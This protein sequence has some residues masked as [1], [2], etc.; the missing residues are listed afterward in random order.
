MITDG[1][2]FYAP[3]YSVDLQGSPFTSKDTTGHLCTV[4][5]A[6]WTPQGRTFD[7]DDEIRAHTVAAGGLFGGAHT[8]IAWAKLSAWA[9]NGEIIGASCAALTPYSLIGFNASSKKFTC[10]VIGAAGENIVTSSGTYNN[11]ANWYFLAATIDAD[12]H[13]N[14]FIVD[15]IDMGAK[16]TFAN[17]I[18]S[19]NEFRIGALAAGVNFWTGT[20]G[21]V[22]VYNRE[23]TVTEIAYIRTQTQRTYK[24]CWDFFTW[25]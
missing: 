9:A 8:L 12:G 15:G 25:G 21:E 2:I 16:S 3:M 23:L 22:M 13:I 10:N 24:A 18:S 19:I 14:H 4:A 20:G 11:D 7:G 6:L 5:G 1:L 17:D